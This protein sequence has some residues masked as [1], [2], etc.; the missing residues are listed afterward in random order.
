MN[1]I[2]RRTIMRMPLI[3]V[4]GD[5]E[6]ARALNQMKEAANC[7]GRPRGALMTDFAI[8]EV[9]KLKSGGH[10]MTVQEITEDGAK[11]I[12]SDGKRVRSE[13]FHPTLLIARDAPI[14][15]INIRIVYPDKDIEEMVAEMRRVSKAQ[16]DT[17]FHVED[18]T[19]RAILK[20]RLGPENE[21][22]TI[23][24]AD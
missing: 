12:W 18:E 23:P 15:G 21:T 8:G 7:G 24:P 17:G 11:C 2:G 14:T 6:F 5:L 9:V 10:E 4:G 1:R 19:A 20:R 13:S 22:R 3:A 16:D